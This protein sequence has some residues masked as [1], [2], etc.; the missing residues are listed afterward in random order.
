[1]SKA[2][3]LLRITE[4]LYDHA[5]K[6]PAPG[7]RDDHINQIETLLKEREMVLSTMSGTVPEA[8]GPFLKKA[9]ELNTAVDARLKEEVSAI[10]MDI[11]RLKKKRETGRRYENSY[12]TPSVDGAFIDRRN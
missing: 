9:A 8:D 10:K 4:R 7:D 12:A 5:V 6:N 11:N 3:E 1:M 2:Y